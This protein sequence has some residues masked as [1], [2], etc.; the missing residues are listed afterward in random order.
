[1]KIFFDKIVINNYRSCKNCE[2]RPN[3]TLS[4]LIGPN[5]SGKTTILRSVLL[6]QKLAYEDRGSFRRRIEEDDL[7]QATTVKVW[8]KINDKT[9]I[10]TN[11]FVLYTDEN[12]EDEIISSSQ[13][14]YMSDI[15]GKKS[16]FKMPLSMASGFGS[17]YDYI[18]ADGRQFY[19]PRK[20]LPKMSLQYLKN[21]KVMKTIAAVSDFYQNIT[22]Y[23][24]SQFTNPSRCPVSFEIEEKKKPI[25]RRSFI[26]NHG[27]WL[28]DM[29]L[30]SKKGTKGFSNYEEI[31]GP[32]GI[33]LV[34]KIEFQENEV[35]TTDV[36]VK[37]G[38]QLKKRK[39]VN[40]IIIPKVHIKGNVLSPTQLSE[41]TFKT[42]AMIFY[43]MT[44][45]SKVILLEE[46]E[47]CIH[48]GLLSSLIE[49]IKQYSSEKQVF[50]ST[51]SDYIID[52]LDSFNVFVVEN[53]N[54]RGIT[55]K[56]LDKWL[57]KQD[58]FALKDFLSSE[59]S[60]GE[61]WRMGG[62]DEN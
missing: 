32:N 20:F 55:V 8:L 36:Y 22:Y 17:Y 56:Q 13:R 33:G 29:Y 11:D 59:G 4:A 15:I 58:R 39:K 3:E 60:L 31:V 7:Y 27:K 62:I 25:R 38:G 41:G 49:L 45:K 16:T 46:P 40:K 26:S 1:M 61:Y 12:N 57:S 24:A 47:V 48:H 19:I 9:V 54:R 21:E 35:S 5:G 37:I 6:L 53:V 34:D 2:F 50:V 52:E 28:Y 18:R 44:G 23:S 14:W 42:L 30:Q 51:H 10:N 43:L